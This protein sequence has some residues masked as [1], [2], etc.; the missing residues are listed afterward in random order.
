MHRY[1]A[2]CYDELIRVTCQ[3]VD[4]GQK[5]LVLEQHKT[6]G[7]NNARPRMIPLCQRAIDIVQDQARDDLDAARPVFLGASG[8]PFTVGADRRYR[9]SE[10]RSSTR[11]V[12]SATTVSAAP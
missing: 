10:T 11:A 12:A 1:M 5:R 7:R 3:D 8:Q 2:A 9:Q 6:S 4:S